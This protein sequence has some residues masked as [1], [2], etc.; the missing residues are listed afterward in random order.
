[1][2]KEPSD[3]TEMVNQVLYGETF[4]ILK[5]QEKWSLIRLHHD[6]YEGWIDNK[7]YVLIKGRKQPQQIVTALFKKAGSGSA[8][9]PMG[10]FIEADDTLARD[11]IFPLTLIATAKKFLYSPYLWGGRTFMG[12]D[13]SGFTQI[14]FRIH[15]IR[16]F[17]DASQ[18]ARQGKKMSFEN[19][20]TGDLAF[21]GKE[22]R[23]THVGIIIR[24]K[25]QTSI[26]HAS[27]RVRI[28]TLDRQGI[29]NNEIKGY[30]HSL[31]S[32]KR[33]S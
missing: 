29:F 31:H 33:I 16:L 4:A 8:V 26:I 30:S 18:Q 19:V 20:Q 22:E 27:G 10:A 32:I 15:G 5:R 25:S 6:R 7:Q 13:C 11:A 3:T 2:R 23:V 12:I 9:L 1:M 17:R 14:A 21:F 28:D 24:E